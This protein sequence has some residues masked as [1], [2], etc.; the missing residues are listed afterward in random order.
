MYNISYLE[1]LGILEAQVDQMLQESGRAKLYLK[2]G[3]C[4]SKSYLVNNG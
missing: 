2:G 3:K 4:V 1:I